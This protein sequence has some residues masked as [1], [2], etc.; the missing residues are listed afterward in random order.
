MKRAVIIKAILTIVTAI[1]AS[2]IVFQFEELIEPFSP[3]SAVIGLFVI[4]CI[5]TLAVD[6]LEMKKKKDEDIPDEEIEK[7][8]LER[9]NSI[10]NF[11]S[12][13]MSWFYLILCMSMII[14]VDPI[15]EFL[16]DK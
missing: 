13:N 10:L 1:I 5:L 12:K 6:I 4:L 16:A 11:L 8:R 15:L 2:L 9:T 7:I 14:L 3:M